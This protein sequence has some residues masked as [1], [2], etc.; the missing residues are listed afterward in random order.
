[1]AKKK[2]FKG[3]KHW[4]ML[5]YERTLKT[6]WWK[7]GTGHKRSHIVWFYWYE[8]CRISKSIWID[9]GAGGQN[10]W[11]LL[12]GTGD[13]NI[14]ELDR[15]EAVVHNTVNVLD[16]WNWTLFNVMNSIIE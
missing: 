14:L 6:L 11:W 15:G 9:L 8:M 2:F 3:V 13:G 4:H 10:R 12:M 5:Q 7:K 16:A 1:M